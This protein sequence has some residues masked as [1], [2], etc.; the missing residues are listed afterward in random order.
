MDDPIDRARA[1]ASVLPNATLSH[2]TAAALTHLDHVDTATPTVTVHASTTHSFPGVVVVR[3]R[4]LL[5][6]H[7]SEV[8]GFRVTTPERTIVDLAAMISVSQLGFVVDAALASRKASYE[9]IR[10]VF[11][12]V[13]R[14]GK[15][16]VTSLRKV[17]DERGI[18]SAGVSVLEARANRILR[19]AGLPRFETEFP[20]PW[21]PGRRF[22]VAFPEHRLA[23]EW[24]S[25]RWHATRESFDKDRR[26]DRLAI[27]HGWRVVRFTWDD[28]EHRPDVIVT[29]VD[30]L[31]GS[32]PARSVG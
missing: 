28:V 22:D 16:G 20:I 21:E 31:L 14:K 32:D 11:V 17:L 27:L 4:D 19:Q 29:T 18:A 23:I 3:S 7:T 2:F 26:R 13:A 30:A 6:R 15:P 8:H 24:D 9:G 1:A 25:H 12:D 10:S 5:V